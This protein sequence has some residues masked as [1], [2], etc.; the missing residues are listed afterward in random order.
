MKRIVF[1]L[2]ILMTLVFLTD[3]KKKYPDDKWGHLRTA[4]IRL[5]KGACT[6][7]GWTD[8]TN[9]RFGVF[10]YLSE[11]IGFFSDGRS[12]GGYLVGNS[13]SSI[14]S[15]SIFNFGGTWDFY[16]G[17]DKIKVVNPNGYFTIWTIDRLDEFYLI[18]HNDS[19]K[20]YFKYAL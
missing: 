18:L 17:E 14:I 2:V 16:D 7:K 4:R 8:L 5:C 20:Y 3:C 13:C 9:C 1:G 19:I 12:D 15:N 11:K 6:L 10:P